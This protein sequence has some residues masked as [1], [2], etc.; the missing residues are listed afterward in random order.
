MLEFS[1]FVISSIQLMLKHTITHSSSHKSHYLES[2]DCGDR[3]C[4]DRFYCD[5]SLGLSF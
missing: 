5:G 2:A 4:D 1:L 3:P